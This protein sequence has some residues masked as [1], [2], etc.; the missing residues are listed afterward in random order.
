MGSGT[1]NKANGHCLY[2]AIQD[3]INRR[4]CF[5]QN[6]ENTPEHYRVVWNTEGE[7][8]V[9]QSAY[10]PGQYSEGEW[11]NAWFKLKYTSVWDLDYFGDLVIISCAHSLK[12]RYFGHQYPL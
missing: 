2:E 9:K 6:L 1:P 5:I 12:K 11:D 7:T 10:Y 3:N 4:D 8:K